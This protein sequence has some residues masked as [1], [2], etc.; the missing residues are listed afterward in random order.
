MRQLFQLTQACT[1][2]LGGGTP[3]CAA[4]FRV[5]TNEINLN[6]PRKWEGEFN[7]VNQSV[8]DGLMIGPIG[9]GGNRFF[10][11]DW[12]RQMCDRLL[13][14]E[15]VSCMSGDYQIREVQATE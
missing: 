10:W 2:T 8:I 6:P 15:V 7:E 1:S 9:A 11:A 4:G 13:A 12:Q 14:G 5:V 3:G